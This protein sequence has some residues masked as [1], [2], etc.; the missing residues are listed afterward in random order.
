M[1]KTLTTAAAVA[2]GTYEALRRARPGGDTLWNRTNHVGRTVTL[3]AGPA[4]AL[5]TA[6]AIA[7]A[8]ALPA[9]HRWAGALTVLTAGA[10]GAYDDVAGDGRRG[11]RAHLSALRRGEVTSGA[12]KLLGIGA[13]GLA[14]G[15][16]L[17]ERPLD[18]LLAAVV[19]AGSAHAVN[20]LD[21]R[22]ARAAGA[23]LALG[24]GG[25]LRGGNGAA[26]AAAPVGAAAALL[27][28][29][30][31]G[32]TMLG[33]TGAHALGAGLGLAVVGANGRTG[34]ALHAVVLVA[35]T[36][37]ADARNPQSG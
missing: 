11:F 1:K 15:A 33:D 31:A 6:T 12:V 37:A 30:A 36:I 9:R 14:A 21:V 18:R 2:R 22:P 27:A 19:I 23:V 26:L 16:V 7:S 10:C 3:C 5:G 29:D 20:L 34:L 4:A 28:D 25:L 35:A 17:K 32:R 24:A 8:R 13:A